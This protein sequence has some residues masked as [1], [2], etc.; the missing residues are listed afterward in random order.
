L[1]YTIQFCPEK[2]KSKN[3]RKSISEPNRAFLSPE[4][5][6][7]MGFW[8]RTYPCDL[9]ALESG[10]TVLFVRFLERGGGK[11]KDKEAFG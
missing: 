10:V 8:N 6:P 1:G 4:E 2:D 11:C 3:R 9:R 7:L 5:T